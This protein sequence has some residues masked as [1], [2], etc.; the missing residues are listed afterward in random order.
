M[1]KE[2]GVGEGGDAELVGEMFS[3]KENPNPID[4]YKP[5]SLSVECSLSSLFCNKTCTSLNA[6]SLSSILFSRVL[7]CKEY[8]I[9]LR[10]KN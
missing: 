1:A 3:G 10:G 6:M 5:R 2:W 8:K 4:R 7:I 9:V